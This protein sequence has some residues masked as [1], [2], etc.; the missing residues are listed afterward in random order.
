MTMYSGPSGQPTL[1][2][3]SEPKTIR[4]DIVDSIRPSQIAPPVVPVGSSS[5][6]VEIR[7]GLAG[8]VMNDSPVVPVEASSE[9]GTA[10]GSLSTEKVELPLSRLL[11]SASR[12]NH[13][14][15]HAPL[16][17]GSSTVTRTISPSMSIWGSPTCCT[18]RLHC[19]ATT[20]CSVLPISWLKTSTISAGDRSSASPSAGVID[21]S[22]LVEPCAAAEGAAET[23]ATNAAS[24]P[25]R[26]R[27]TRRA[28]AT[29]GPDGAREGTEVRTLTTNTVATAARSPGA[30]R[31][32]PPAPPRR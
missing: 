26:S 18:S 28:G 21:C 1:I 23:T 13:V 14:I 20:T 7:V 4:I 11:P 8:T 15:E 32:S 24:N 30:S 16:G 2:S 19:T 29:P 27:S 31:P 22:E 6:S 5:A 10:A 9:T 12:R 3:A 17:K 25:A